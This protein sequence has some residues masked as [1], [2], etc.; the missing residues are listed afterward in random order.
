MA[1]RWDGIY[2]IIS[3]FT[4]RLGPDGAVHEGWCAIFL[5]QC[6]SC[7]DDGRGRGGRRVRGDD[8]GAKVKAPPAAELENA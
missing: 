3:P 6:C 5:L 8:G 4:K 2:K 1:K 7:K